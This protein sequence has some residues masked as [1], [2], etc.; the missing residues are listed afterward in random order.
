M[1]V[2]NG[3]DLAHS[4]AFLARDAGVKPCSARRTPRSSSWAS[5]MAQIWPIARRSWLGTQ[6]GSRARHGDP[7]DLARGAENGPEKTKGPEFFC[8][9]G[10][11][12]LWEEVR[13]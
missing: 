7:E 10:P 13:L 8:G 5:R 1:G 12:L 6:G 3:P 2:A 11:S 4:S 9:P